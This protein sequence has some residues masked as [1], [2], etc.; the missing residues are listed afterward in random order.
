ML[1]DIQNKQSALF[2]LAFHLK[3]HPNRAT[4]FLA[5]T[6][7]LPHIQPRHIQLYRITSLSE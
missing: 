7:F 4:S 6:V 2:Y 3:N 5:V 1:S